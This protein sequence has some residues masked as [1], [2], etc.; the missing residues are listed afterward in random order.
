MTATT[1]R[2]L[3]ILLALVGVMVITTGI[4]WMAETDPLTPGNWT[5][6]V[7]DAIGPWRI[8]LTLVRWAVWCALWWCWERVGQWLFWGEGESRKAQHLHWSG[9]RNRMMGSLAAAEAIILISHLLG[10]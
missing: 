1:K 6:E 2:L 7:N 5:G 4:A 9:M 8:T 3:L 10:A